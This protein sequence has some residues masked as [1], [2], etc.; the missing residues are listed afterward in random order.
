MN[1][2][3]ENFRTH[4]YSLYQNNFVLRTWDRKITV[5]GQKQTTRFKV[6]KLFSLLASDIFLLLLFK[7]ST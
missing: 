7:Q 6:K 5:F 1:E 3:N 4:L 2:K